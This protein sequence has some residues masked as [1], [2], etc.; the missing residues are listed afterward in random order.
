MKQYRGYYIDNAIFNSTQD[1]DNFIKAEALRAYRK[2]IELFAET[3]TPAASV[4]ADQKA[5]KLV[6]EFG[7][8]WE[9]VEAI[10]IET[11]E[12]IA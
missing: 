11:L 12:S 6:N 8:T 3:R 9:E 1:I 4:W 7:Y 10:E 2:A 5:E